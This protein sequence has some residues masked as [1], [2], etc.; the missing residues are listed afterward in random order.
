MDIR[1]KRLWKRTLERLTGPTGS[2]IIHVLII[3]A[4]IK[5]V[6]YKAQDKAPE[7]EVM[8]ME[9]DAQELEEFEKELEKLEDIPQVDQI[10]PPE[11][12]ME[13]EAPPEVD[14]FAAPEPDV[15][16]AAMDM[17]DSVQSPLVMKGLFAGRSSGGRAAALGA[18]GGEW[19]KYTEAAV[20]R[21][22]EWLKNHQLPDGSWGGGANGT[23]NRNKAAMTGL[24]ILTFLAHGETTSSEKYGPTV[25]KAIRFLVSQ[26]AENGEFVK[27]V[28]PE[29]KGVDNAPAYAHAIATY[30]ISEAYGMTRIPSLKPVMEKAV[31]VILK[32]Q[33]AG[34]GWDYGYRKTAR[35]DT[36][37]SGWHI[38]A[39]KAAYIGGAENP[40]IKESM[41]KALV[42]LK[43][44]FHAESGHFNYTDSGRRDSITA[45]AVLCFQL[46]GHAEEKESRAGVQT[47]SGTS[48]DWQKPL[49][50]PMYAWYYITQ[51]KFHVGGQTWSGWNAKFARQFV[52]NQNEDG[53][54]T[55]AGKNLGEGSH[56]NEMSYGPVYSTTLAALTLQVYYRFLPT[57][58]AVAVE[59]VDQ[60]SADDVNV[61]IL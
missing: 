48:C 3:V 20:L 33:Q 37:V 5:L 26:Q 18:Y 43:S 21:A 22:L 17:V 58:K 35:R 40:G 36:S 52:R 30:A 7:I 12:N 8:M 10:T 24:G 54:W 61:Q 50:W 29:A 4:L 34:G 6:T 47:L 14:D 23:E 32:G 9:P 31:D 1:V 46:T 49:D 38:Q 41:D 60:K 2:A 59:P 56:G 16:Y 51:T 15:D 55:S 19:A 13:V 27:V 25:E 53:S 28:D 57:Y 11:V 42:D 45:V 39:L 44:A